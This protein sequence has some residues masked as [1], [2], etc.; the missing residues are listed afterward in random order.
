LHEADA[1]FSQTKNKYASKYDERRRRRKEHKKLFIS[2]GGKRRKK[3]EKELDWRAPRE[4]FLPRFLPFVKT[5]MTN[6][7]KYLLM[8][9][10]LQSQHL[11]LSQ[12]V[13]PGVFYKQMVKIADFLQYGT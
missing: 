6:F 5:N 2:G 3:K 12:S 11:F 13:Y 7:Q 9:L 10:L 1:L 8:L 4:N